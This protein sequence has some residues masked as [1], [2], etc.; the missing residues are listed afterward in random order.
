MQVHF[1]GGTVLPT[2]INV[3]LISEKVKGTNWTRK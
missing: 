2:P 3:L 1:G